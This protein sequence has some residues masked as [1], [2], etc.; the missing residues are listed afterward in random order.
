[1]ATGRQMTVGDPKEQ[2]RTDHAAIRRLQHTATV[3]QL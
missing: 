3:C 1:M 2:S